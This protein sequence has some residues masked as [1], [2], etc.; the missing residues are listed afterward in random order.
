MSGCGAGNAASTRRT[1]I[2][3]G[4]SEVALETQVAKSILGGVVIHVSGQVIDASVRT[5]LDAMRET[6]RRVRVTE[7][8]QEGFLPLNLTALADEA[9]RATEPG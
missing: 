2:G 1:G 9:R 7:F 4:A 8:D 5:Y 3:T 6:L